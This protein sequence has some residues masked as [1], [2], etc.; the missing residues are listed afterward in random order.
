M[1]VLSSL[2]V[3]FLITGIAAARGS[4]TNSSH[5]PD[6]KVGASTILMVNNLVK[7]YAVDVRHP[8]FMWVMGR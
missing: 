7:P 1:K 5:S 2:T 4:G 6:Q 3:F 8:T